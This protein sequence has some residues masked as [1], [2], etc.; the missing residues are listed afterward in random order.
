MGFPAIAIGIG[1]RRLLFAGFF[2]VWLALFA[3][4]ANVDLGAS[5]KAALS[6]TPSTALLLLLV[7]LASITAL[8][9]AALILLAKI[10]VKEGIGTLGRLLLISMLIDNMAFQVM[11]LGEAVF[12]F[13]ISKR[14]RIPFSKAAPLAVVMNA[15]WAIGITAANLVIFLIALARGKL[16]TELF[17]LGAF[18]FI[19]TCALLLLSQHGGVKKIIASLAARL[20]IK[21][22]EKAF[23]SSYKQMCSP[24]TVAGASLMQAAFHLLSIFFIYLALE[25]FGFPLDF[26]S[27]GFIYLSAT[28]SSLLIFFIPISFDAAA[29]ALLAS[30]G[31]PIGVAA[32]TIGTFRFFFYWLFNF[33][34]AYFAFREPELRKLGI[35]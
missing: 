10:K 13:L 17:V 21:L 27:V 5:I 23:F 16:F 32:L 34:G 28:F 24:P 9:C 1:A 12:A 18:V 26:V 22:G 6:L 20:R 3:L 11:P 15:T 2:I 30:Y 35:F 19:S 29:L 25:A 33:A 8:A 7:F 4:L 14:H 31:A